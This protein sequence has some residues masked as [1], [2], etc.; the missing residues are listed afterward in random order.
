[1]VVLNKYLMNE[2]MKRRKRKQKILNVSDQGDTMIY[3]KAE[4]L[5]LVLL[6]SCL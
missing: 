2:L 5:H 4:Y 6:K 1:M 3:P